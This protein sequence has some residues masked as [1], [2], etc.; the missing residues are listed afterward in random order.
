[1]TALLLVQMSGAPGAGK[2]T[3]ARAIGRRTGAA[4]LDHDVTKSALLEAGVAAAVAGQASYQMLLALGRSLL[5]QGISVV[6]DSPCYYQELL[7][8]GLHMAAETNACYRYVEC[9]TE[10]LVEL[11]RR[12]RD[13]PPLRSQVLDLAATSARSTSGETLSGEELF[14]EWIRNMKRPAHSY[15]RVDTSRPLGDCL[16]AVFAFLTECGRGRA[17]HEP[18]FQ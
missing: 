4:V 5:D 15:L 8:A 1:M 10:D 11:S 3:V 9:A 18:A 12:L 16:P 17:A 14:R 13:R 6:L 7:D 2:S